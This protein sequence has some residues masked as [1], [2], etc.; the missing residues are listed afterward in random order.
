MPRPG[1]VRGRDLHAV[2]Q[3]AHLVGAPAVNRH[4]H[5]QLALVAA[6]VLRVGGTASAGIS[7]TNAVSALPAVGSVS[8]VSEVMMLRGCVFWTST[9]GLG[10][11]DRDRLLE[12]ADAQVGVDGGGEVGRQLDAVAAAPMLKP[13]SVNVTA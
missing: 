3:P 11:G 5:R 12:R 4:A 1:A 6:D 13:G 7:A 8:R 2:L 10:A 9:T